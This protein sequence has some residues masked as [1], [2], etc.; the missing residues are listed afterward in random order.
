MALSTVAL[1]TA[2]AQSGLKI[3]VV[4]VV[5]L[6]EESPQA[7][8]MTAALQD[9]FAPRQR[10]LQAMEREL[11]QKQE[12]FRRDSSVMGEEERLNLERQIRD[13]QRDLQRAQ[14]EAIEDWNIRLNEERGKLNRLL[15]QQV[16]QYARDQ[17]YDLVV[18]DALYFSDAIDITGEVLE[19]LQKQPAT[20]SR[21][22]SGSSR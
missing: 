20:T 9:E 14:N 1:G 18:A 22:G 10:E 13:G 7:K 11:Q 8:A 19:A 15:L 3:G 21:S 4:N 2:D 17:K 16:Q 6:L 12:T 5:R